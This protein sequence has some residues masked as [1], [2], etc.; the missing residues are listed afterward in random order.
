MQPTDDGETCHKLVQRTSLPGGKKKLPEGVGR[1]R[2][3]SRSSLSMEDI[4][5]F[6]ILL[7]PPHAPQDLI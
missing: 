7:P 1:L 4:V 6:L 5:Y 3:D 2:S